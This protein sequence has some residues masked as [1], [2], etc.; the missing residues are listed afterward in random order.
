MPDEVLVSGLRTIVSMLAVSMLRG[1][2]ALG[3]LLCARSWD[4]MRSRTAGVSKGCVVS[5]GA[6]KATSANALSRMIGSMMRKR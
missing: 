3:K 5:T 1:L 6:H 4:V 2:L